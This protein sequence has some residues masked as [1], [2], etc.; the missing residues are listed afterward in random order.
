MV[1]ELMAYTSW[2]LL[3][4]AGPS[5]HYWG[6]GK[7]GAE[8]KGCQGLL[9]PPH[10]HLQISV[11]LDNVLANFQF[12]TK[13]FEQEKKYKIYDACKTWV[14]L[15]NFNK[16]NFFILVISCWLDFPNVRC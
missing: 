15:G 5:R 2:W 14:E 12:L 1:T 10:L 11:A 3:L 8:Y 13:N 4:H 7:N 6:F 16:S 9:P